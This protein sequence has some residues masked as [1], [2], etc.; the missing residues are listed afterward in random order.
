MKKMILGLMIV[1]TSF[2]YADMPNFKDM[3]S[4]MDRE[5]STIHDKFKS[6]ETSVGMFVHTKEDK[7]IRIHGTMPGSRG[8]QLNDKM[9]KELLSKGSYESKNEEIPELGLIC[10]ELHYYF[11]KDKNLALGIA[12][13]C[14]KK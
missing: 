7:F 12:K 8:T 4:D 9:T 10:Q 14:E 11:D 13:G 6:T 5:L 2:V 3:I 1:G